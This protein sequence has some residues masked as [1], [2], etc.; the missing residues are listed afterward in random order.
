MELSHCLIIQKEHF[1]ENESVSIL[2]SKA[3]EVP[4]QLALTGLDSNRYNDD[5]D[6][7]SNNN[8]NNNN[9]NTDT[10]RHHK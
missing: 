4:T 2:R 3:R 8:N 7:D 10:L 1:S 9:N 6:D 5:D